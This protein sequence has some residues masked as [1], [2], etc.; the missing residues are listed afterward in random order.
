MWKVHEQQSSCM[1]YKSKR[2]AVPETQQIRTPLMWVHPEVFVI[3]YW[4]HNNGTVIT[5]QNRWQK[6]MQIARRLRTRQW[7]RLRL[8]YQV[9]I[10][11]TNKSCASLF[12]TKQPAAIT[13]A[14][15]LHA[16]AL[17]NNSCRN[18]MARLHFKCPGI[19]IL[20]ATCN[21]VVANWPYRSAS[22]MFN[23]NKKTTYYWRSH[24]MKCLASNDKEVCANEYLFII[25]NCA[26]L[27]LES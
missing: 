10:C 3:Q 7:I 22:H 1:Q 21:K 14:T 23:G 5:P 24:R 18:H 27:L 9:E 17:H 4:G 19:Y 20:V 26:R 8:L 16:C 11:F 13:N 12:R 15:P 25:L 6:N 2:K